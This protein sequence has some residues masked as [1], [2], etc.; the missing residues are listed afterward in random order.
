MDALIDKLDNP[1]SLYLTVDWILNLA[2]QY[3]QLQSEAAL[4]RCYIDDYP[5][6]TDAVSVT[7]LFCFSRTLQMTF[8]LT[9]RL[10]FAF[11]FTAHR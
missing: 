2:E 3:P 9:A 1:E 4:I 8:Q 5:E 7:R 6:F 10:L 11:I